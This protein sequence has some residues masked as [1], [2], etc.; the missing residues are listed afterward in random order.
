LTTNQISLEVTQ[1]FK[2]PANARFASN[3]IK[4]ETYTSA[5]DMIDAVSSGLITVPSCN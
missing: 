4:I 3:S 5:G 1:G 2:N